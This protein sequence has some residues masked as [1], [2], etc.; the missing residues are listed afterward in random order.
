MM[1]FGVY[2]SCWSSHFPWLPEWTPQQVY[3]ALYGGLAGAISVVGNTP[4]DVI[5]TRMQVPLRQSLNLHLIALTE[6]DLTRQGTRTHSTVQSKRIETRDSSLSTKEPCHAWHAL[7]LT[8]PLFLCFT[9][10]CLN[11]WMSYAPSNALCKMIKRLRNLMRDT[12]VYLVSLGSEKQHP[13][14]IFNQD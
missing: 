11:C 3:T 8:L 6:R 9:R 2:E 7:L 10:K 13:F 5:K 12:F 1:R 14:S 4:L